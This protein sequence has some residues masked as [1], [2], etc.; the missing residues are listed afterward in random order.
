MIEVQERVHGLSLNHPST[1]LD[2]LFPRAKAAKS[3]LRG[4][5]HACWA[6]SV[7]LAQVR[8]K[9]RTVYFVFLPGRQ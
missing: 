8:Y 5:L 4:L 2:L 3:L 6:L 1:K 7:D 9:L